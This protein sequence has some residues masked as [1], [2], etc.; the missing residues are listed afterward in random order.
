ML[1]P[2]CLLCL[3]QG[4]LIKWLC[5]LPVD[6]ATEWVRGRCSCRVVATLLQRPLSRAPLVQ[7]P[8]QHF[9]WK[10]IF[11]LK[12]PWNQNEWKCKSIMSMHFYQTQVWSVPFL[13]IHSIHVFAQDLEA[14]TSAVWKFEIL[15]RPVDNRGLC[16]VFYNES[17]LAFHCTACCWIALSNRDFVHDISH[18]I[19]SY[20]KCQSH[21]WLWHW[22]YGVIYLEVKEGQG[23][24]SCKR[25]KN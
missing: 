4:V 7:Q 14:S 20:F 24:H 5:Q 10:D 1:N 9:D 16:S 2:H 25:R 3:V 12:P 8:L 22:N 17:H 13:V 23:E 18:H 6:W 15:L 21:I 19:V 11:W